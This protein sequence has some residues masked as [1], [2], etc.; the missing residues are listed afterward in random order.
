VK[1]FSVSG[2]EV[3]MRVGVTTLGAVSARRAYKSKG[4][5]RL[6]GGVSAKC[7]GREHVGCTSL[8]CRCECHP[9]FSS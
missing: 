3:G 5:P 8:A 7:R 4:G 9:R 2:R 6:K 1:W